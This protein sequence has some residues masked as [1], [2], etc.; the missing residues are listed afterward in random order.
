MSMPEKRGWFDKPEN[1]RLFI[2]L[3]YSLLVLLVAADFMVEG[4]PHFPWEAWPGFFA[5][6]GFICFVA[7]VFAARILRFFIKREED[8]YDR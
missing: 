8:Y 7:M 6:Y 2:R 1:F 3:F 5:A 4:H